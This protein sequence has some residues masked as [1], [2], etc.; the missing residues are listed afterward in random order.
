MTR[1]LLL[2]DS[3]GLVF[4]FWGGRPL[5]R[6]DGSVF[7]ICCW[8]LPAQSFSGPSPLILETICYCLRFETFF[9]VASYDSQCRSRGIRP[10]LHTGWTLLLPASKLF[11]IT[12]LHGPR[13]KHSHS[14]VGKAC[15]QCRYI[16]TEVTRLFA[17]SLPLE[18]G[19]RV[20]AWQWTSIL[21]SLYR[22]SGVISQYFRYR[23][24][25]LGKQS[26][27]ILEFK[28]SWQIHSVSGVLNYWTRQHVQHIVSMRAKEQ[29]S[30]M[31]A[32]P[33]SWKQTFSPSRRIPPLVITLT[34]CEASD[35]RFGRCNP[36]KIA[37]STLWMR[38]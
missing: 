1:C 19:C 22:L 35:S 11:F 3:Y 37:F 13:R 12:T 30:M 8:S 9:F 16:A 5:W 25:L 24:S 17:Y 6:E 7:C 26:L 38:D 4:I 27:V 32:F 15:L 2:F 33:W 29:L 31:A 18:C 14:I 21:T 36:E 23:F 10:R 20:V 34:E 28:R